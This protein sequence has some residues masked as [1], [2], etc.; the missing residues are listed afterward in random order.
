MLYQEG[1]EELGLDVPLA[2][3]VSHKQLEAFLAREVRR[4]YEEEVI[5]RG[6]TRV[7]EDRRV[8]P[9]ARGSWCAPSY[10]E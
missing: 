7:R 4:Y 10:V 2:C 5:P 6:E 1:V 9:G 3:R 8:L